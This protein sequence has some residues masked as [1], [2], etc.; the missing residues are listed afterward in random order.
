MTYLSRWTYYIAVL[1]GLGLA[2]TLAIIFG[3]LSPDSWYYMLIAQSLRQGQGCALYGQYMAA[4]PCGYPLALALTAPSADLP[5]LMVS[6]KVTN[7][8]L[9]LGSFALLLGALK[10]RL[11]VALAVLNPVSLH[12][13]MY[14]WS[15]NLFLL[16]VCGVFFAL[17]RLA[18]W[19]ASR[20]Y[21]AVLCASLLMGCLTRYVFGP[22]ALILFLGAWR[23]YGRALAVRVLPAFVGAGLV[24]I[25]YQQ[26]NIHLTGFPTGME[27]VAAPESAWLLL[28]TFFT[29]LGDLAKSLLVAAA[30]LLG[31]SFRQISLSRKMDEPA[32]FQAARFLILAGAGFLLLA[33]VLRARTF[34]D[35]Y[36]A[37]TLGLGA[38]FMVAGLVARF[39]RLNFPRGLSVAAAVGVLGLWSCLWGDDGSIRYALGQMRQGHHRFAPTALDSLRRPGPEADMIVTFDIPAA[40]PDLWNVETIRAIYYGPGVS[41]VFPGRGP[42]SVPPQTAASFVSE[43][44]RNAGGR[45]YVDFVAFASRDDFQAYL[46][47]ATTIDE[48]LFPKPGQPRFKEKPRFDPGLKAYL[49]HIFRPG[50]FVP[51]HDIL[52][53][54]ESLSLLA[55]AHPP[56]PV[57]RA[58]FRN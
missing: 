11:A 40:G 54:P 31:L 21:M 43:I 14:T 45:C 12:I 37:R 1:A 58:A 33:F 9:M 13:Y 2:M 52:S 22:F 32:T 8:L 44:A 7:L 25:A 26:L 35:P 34:Y 49:A 30:I 51:C 39:V 3:F 24:Y 19:P 23:V 42:D 28:R 46:D 4:Y 10:H 6:G 57:N 27:R 55:A 48:A 47:G 38:V 18:Q 29:V 36:D 16:C 5:V 56:A 53:Q 50:A 15:E 41:L 17:T 20:R